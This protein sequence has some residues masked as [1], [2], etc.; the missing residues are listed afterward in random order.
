TAATSGALDLLLTPDPGVDLGISARTACA[1]AAS[2]LGCLDNGFGGEVEDLVVPV[3]AGQQIFVLVQGFNQNFFGPFT[4][5]ISSR[6]IVCGNDLTD[7]GETCDGTDLNGQDCRS[8]GFDS[9]ALSCLV[10]C[11]AFDTSGCSFATA[12]HGALPQLPANGGPI[13]DA[14]DLVTIVF[15]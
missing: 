2:E 11:S 10:D 5:D 12:A 9:G 13:F 14:I 3:S 1:D 6:A 8:L 15:Q 7:P 4:L